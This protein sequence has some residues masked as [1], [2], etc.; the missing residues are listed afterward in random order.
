[1]EEI[2]ELI[3]A[4]VDNDWD[5]DEWFF[6]TQ[7]IFDL[8]NENHASLLSDLWIKETELTLLSPEDK[9]I[10]DKAII[11]YFILIWIQ[12]LPYLWAPISLWVDMVDTY[13]DSDATAELW[14]KL[15]MI[16]WNY[17]IW[18]QWYDNVLG[19]VW[20]VLTGVWIQWIAKWEK[21]ASSYNSLRK[22]WFWRVE[23][24]L[25]VMWEKL[26][27]TWE[28]LQVLKNYFKKLFEWNIKEA[29]K[30]VSKFH[31]YRWIDYTY[32]SPIKEIEQLLIK[33]D[34]EKVEKLLS[35]DSKKLYFE[36]DGYKNFTKLIKT[37]RYGDA[38]EIFKKAE[39][40]TI[41]KLDNI[42]FTIEDNLKFYEALKTW[43]IEEIKRLIATSKEKVWDVYKWVYN[44]TSDSFWI[45]RDE[46]VDIEKYNK[47][48]ITRNPSTW[49]EEML[50]RKE[51]H[52]IIISDFLK[53]LETKDNPVYMVIWWM[54]WS[55]KSEVKKW[56]NTEIWSYIEID[57]DAIRRYLPEFS[58][59]VPETSI[60]THQESLFIA[61]QL[62]EKAVKMKWNLLRETIM[63]RPEPLYNY[64]EKWAESHIMDFRF[65]FSWEESWLRNTLWRDRTV[66]PQ[67]YIS[68]FK[69]FETV[70]WL[71]MDTSVKNLKIY[72]NI[73]EKEIIYEKVDWV[74]TPT[75]WEWM[76]KFFMFSKI[77]KNINN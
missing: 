4:K 50:S 44:N 71:M 26:W 53:W 52:E 45:T 12:M 19:W 36:W 35:S 15:W 57:P 1:M 28:R 31:D 3:K 43:N 23:D 61:K 48:E 62:L 38:F 32:K 75:S 40:D 59:N 76:K 29:E 18:K 5:F 70:I 63:T 47:K 2:S 56:L 39:L 68:Q 24:V 8:D 21:L 17:K 66:N 64:I 14:K 10:E 49:I 54:S 69:A 77:S 72:L 16:D 65:V 6:S 67:V 27:I 34:F 73:W 25:I 41:K 20:L 74:I 55:W 11:S 37:K 13:S 42:W 7:K 46:I 60:T 22:I 30:N 51:L 9:E 33:W 58:E